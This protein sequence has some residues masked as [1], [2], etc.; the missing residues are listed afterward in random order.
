MAF[1]ILYL[2]QQKQT[3]FLIRV[4]DPPQQSDKLISSLTIIIIIIKKIYIP[5]NVIRVS[6]ESDA[7]RRCQ[8]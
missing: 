1:K 3:P 6:Y 5:H 7:R 8:K 4:K 2:L